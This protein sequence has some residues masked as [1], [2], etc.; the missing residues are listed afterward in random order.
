MKIAIHMMK[1]CRIDLELCNTKYYQ[2][3]RSNTSLYIAR[4]SAWLSVSHRINFHHA[5]QKFKRFRTVEA[6]SF[7]LR[8]T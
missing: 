6:H 7:S 5:Q 1:Q 3:A 2:K 8:S 4:L